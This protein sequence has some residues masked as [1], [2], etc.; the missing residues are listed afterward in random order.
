MSNKPFSEEDLDT[1]AEL[2]A[3]VNGLQEHIYS[4]EKQ[5]IES[6][7]AR[8]QVTIATLKNIK[9]LL[10]LAAIVVAAFAS[11]NLLPA[12]TKESYASKYLDVLLAGSLA[13]GGLS[14]LVKQTDENR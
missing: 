13:A 3:V 2:V 10:S 11:Y 5:L 14:A 12:E 6:N 8:Y 7:N 1:T 4:L 9:Q